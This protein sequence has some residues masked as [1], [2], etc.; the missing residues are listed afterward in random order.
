MQASAE[1]GAGIH[2]GPCKHPPDGMQAT[3][4]GRH[5]SPTASPSR[6]RSHPRHPALDAGPGIHQKTLSPA[7]PFNLPTS[8][9]TTARRDAPRCV[10]PFPQPLIFIVR[11]PRRHPLSSPPHTVKTQNL[12]SPPPS[13][14]PRTNSGRRKIMR[15]YKATRIRI[16]P[17][18][19]THRNSHL[20][21]GYQ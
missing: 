9:L 17:P 6:P 3:G 14:Q 13:S 18:A 11:L 2:R 8:S 10:R 19:I 7:Y 4:D 20:Q 12:A 16:R 21:L 1:G 15:L 5:A